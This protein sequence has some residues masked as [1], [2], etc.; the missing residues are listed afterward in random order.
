MYQILAIKEC[1]NN[2]L[3]IISDY[4]RE[5]K[6]STLKTWIFNTEF[7]FN[8]NLKG[9]TQLPR[10]NASLEPYALSRLYDKEPQ[11][12]TNQP[13]E[14]A[15]RR[16]FHRSSLAVFHWKCRHPKSLPFRNLSLTNW[17]SLFFGFFPPSKNTELTLISVEEG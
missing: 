5:I 12:A 4:I 16:N 3:N 6:Q 2:I 15:E 11:T 14:P 13:H 9:I 17:P 8:S 7:L 1:F 10:S